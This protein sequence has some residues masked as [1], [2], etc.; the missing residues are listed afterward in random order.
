MAKSAFWKH[1]EM[2]QRNISRKTKL[3]LM[4]TYIFSI[5]TYGCE[6][7]TLNND[8]D[9]RITSFENWCYRR[10]LRIN[11][12]DRITNNEVLR[13]IGKTHF[14]WLN[15]IRE[16]KI[17]FAGHVLRGSSGELLLDVIEGD[18]DRPRGRGRPRRMWS[19]DVKEWLNVRSMAEF[20]TLA[21]DRQ[22]FRS[23]A[24]EALSRLATIVHDEA[25]Q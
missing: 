13:R 25:T 4:Q 17:K 18:C 20:K 8:L 14:E 15:I 19:N 7:W 9:R 21:N 16:R 3:R 10:M 6:S 1:K 24:N 12:Q 23:T 22:L 5:L 11:W 2:M